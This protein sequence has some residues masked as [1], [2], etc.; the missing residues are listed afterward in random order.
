MPLSLRH[1]T[2][3][4]L[5]VI[6]GQA[7]KETGQG[8]PPAPGHCPRGPGGQK[9]P[10]SCTHVHTPKQGLGTLGGTEEDSGWP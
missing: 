7:R 8:S 5:P 6:R 3:A 1:C 2:E 10:C 9:C 4:G